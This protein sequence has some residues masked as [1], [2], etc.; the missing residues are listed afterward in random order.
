MSRRD[1]PDV[2]A[3]AAELQQLSTEISPR[4]FDALMRQWQSSILSDLAEYIE[5]P[6]D[7][8]D[9]PKVETR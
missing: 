4:R 7:L 5:I 1:V 9:L 2:A 3:L 6:D 8:A